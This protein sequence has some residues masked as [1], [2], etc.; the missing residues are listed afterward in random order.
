MTNSKLRHDS[1]TFFQPVWKVLTPYRILLQRTK[2]KYYGRG[3]QFID[4]I[5]PTIQMFGDILIGFQNTFT[6]LEYA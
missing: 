4:I 3:E 5:L 6:Y 1:W 2:F